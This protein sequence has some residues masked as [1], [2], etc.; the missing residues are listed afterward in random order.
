MQ[1]T[2][3]LG[4]AVLVIFVTV[5]AI[6]LKLMPGPRKDSDYLVIGSVATFLSLAAVFV[7]VIST[8]GKSSNL[9]GVFFKRR[10]KT[11]TGTD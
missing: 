6:L 5:T 1:K 2:R 3:I 10:R 7:L 9:S 11:K 8:S 4:I